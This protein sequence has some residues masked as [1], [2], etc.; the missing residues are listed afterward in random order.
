MKNTN[1]N[2]TEISKE[3]SVSREVI[4]N[5]NTGKTYKKEDIV[6]PIRKRYIDKIIVDEIKLLLKNTNMYYKD[7][8]K[9]TNTSISIVSKINYG[10]A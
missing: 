7:I 8:A 5:I 10:T 1:K 9:S 2:F 4:Q 3:L 6:Y